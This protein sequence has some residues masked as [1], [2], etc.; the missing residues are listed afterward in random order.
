MRSR[1]GIRMY[2]F[3]LIKHFRQLQDQ[4]GFSLLEALTTVAIAV[5]VVTGAH[6]SYVQSMRGARSQQS[7][8]TS[9]AL[10]S[11]I[12]SLAVGSGSYVPPIKFSGGAFA[13]IGC[14]DRGGVAVKNNLATTGL[15]MATKPL[16]AK[17]S[18]YCG[19]DAHFE[20]RIFAKSGTRVA[21]Q[22]WEHNPSSGKGDFILVTERE[23][24]P[25]EG[26]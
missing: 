12:L 17:L 15:V 8:I 20:A 24:D 4:R 26:I 25:P 2:D 14:Y 3:S 6:F 10:A 1:G 19:A 18:G 9:K 11:Q 5:I 23:Y 22:I 13:Y 21:V 16:E 7:N